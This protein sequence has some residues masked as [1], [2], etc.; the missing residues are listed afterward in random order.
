MVRIYTT[1]PLSQKH[2]DSIMEIHQDIQVKVFPSIDH[3]WDYLPEGEVMITYGEDLTEEAI[4]EAKGLNWIQ[5]ISAGLEKMPMQ[6]IKERGILVTNARGIHRVPMSEYT[7]GA[8]LAI[9][10]RSYIFYD[11]Q[12]EVKWDRSVRIGELEGKTL[13]IVGLGAIGQE[14]AKKAKV[15]NMRVIGIKNT[16]EALEFVDRVGDTSQLHDMLRE[17]DYVVVTVPLTPLTRG[18]FGRREFESMKGDAW[19][20]NISRGEVV[21]QEALIDALTR[22][23]IGGAVLDVY[24]PEP[25]PG[26]SPLWKLD[27]VIMTPHV[28]G[29][30]RRYMQRAMEIFRHNLKVYLGI[31]GERMVNVIDPDKGY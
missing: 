23:S 31:S 19:F 29:R 10:R 14:I 26:D 17:S 5:V 15:F 24:T 12:K 20:I 8:M 30:S 3:A 6:A 13:C 28:S 4:R 25:L 18:M 22:K 7:L 1:C 11:L 16:P 21:D 27:N 9:E 2:V